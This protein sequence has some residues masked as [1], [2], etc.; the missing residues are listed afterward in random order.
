MEAE[1]IKETITYLKQVIDMKFV[2]DATPRMSSL[3]KVRD[4]VSNISHTLHTTRTEPSSNFADNWNAES[5]RSNR[6]STLSGKN[7]D[8]TARTTSGYL[9]SGLTSIREGGNDNDDLDRTPEVSVDSTSLHDLVLTLADS[10]KDGDILPPETEMM[11][12][13][14]DKSDVN[15]KRLPERKSNSKA[16]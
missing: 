14:A 3:R 9:G 13:D 16:V 6:S 7:L 1:T 5:Q 12:I 2:D 15:D 4:E 11:P 10:S 8:N